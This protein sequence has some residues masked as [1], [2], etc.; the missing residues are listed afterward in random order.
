MRNIL[1]LENTTILSNISTF[2][3]A[4]V[5]CV[6][7]VL[8]VK[9]SKEQ[10][11]ISQFENRKKIYDFLKEFKDNWLL[12]IDFAVKREERSYFIAFNGFSDDDKEVLQSNNFSNDK[13][14][15]SQSN[16]IMRNITSMK[17]YYNYQQ[18]RL[19]EVGIYYNFTKKDNQII[20]QL[21]EVL[22]KYFSEVLKFT[23]ILVNS[24]ETPDSER[25]KN[26]KKMDD[27]VEKFYKLLESKEL[28]NIIRKMKKE[29]SIK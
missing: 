9:L 10:Y 8:S 23:D 22:E 15:K 4:F 18:D 6:A 25:R 16:Y 12:Y 3:G 21:S 17:K 13:N 11:K 24:P 5:S 1:N 29:I 7:I 28:E 19:N 20:S 2:V 26:L 27:L 14:N